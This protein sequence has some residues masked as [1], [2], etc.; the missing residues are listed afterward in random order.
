MF[1][2]RK[3]ARAVALREFIAEVLAENMPML[4]VFTRCGLSM[5]DPAGSGASST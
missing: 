3:L 4:K 2:V 5:I 1:N